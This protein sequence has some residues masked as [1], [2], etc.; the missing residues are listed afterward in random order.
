MIQAWWKDLA[1]TSEAVILV[2]ALHYEELG[3]P[4]LLGQDWQHVLHVQCSATPPPGGVHLNPELHY[5]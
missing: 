2:I 4:V 3:Q 5:Q 1:C